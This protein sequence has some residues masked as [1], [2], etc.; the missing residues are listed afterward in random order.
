VL[1]FVAGGLIFPEIKE[2]ASAFF[3]MNQ[4]PE[5]EFADPIIEQ[6][7]RKSLGKTPEEA[8]Y[9]QDLLSVGEI[10]IVGDQGFVSW[11]ERGNYI[12]TIN[13]MGETPLSATFSSVSDITACKNLRILS[14]QHN[15]L[16]NIDFLEENTLLTDLVLESTVVTDIS[17]IRKLPMLVSLR[18]DG[19]VTDLSPIKDCTMIEQIA[20]HNINAA[21]YDFAVPGKQYEHITFGN[22]AYEK[23]MP[24]L[25]GVNTKRLSV[26]H[27]GITTFDVFPDMTVTETLDITNN[28]ITDTTG[29]ERILAEGGEILR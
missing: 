18:L 17:V 23:F 19:P 3:G 15:T 25:A 26:I 7:I 14:I 9:P 1:C 29:A 21:N 6:A 24:Y 13:K 11:N 8:V 22:V 27:C 10:Y 5:Y 2:N 12:N 16:D 4:T 28:N 20:F